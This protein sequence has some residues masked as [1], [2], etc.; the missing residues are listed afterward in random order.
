LGETGRFAQARLRWAK[1]LD[2]PTR[3]NLPLF[4]GVDHTVQLFTQ[5]RQV[6]DLAV[7]PRGNTGRSTV[8]AFTVMP[9]PPDLRDVLPS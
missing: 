7:I 4:A 3:C 8:N 6:G 5:C 2:D 9:I 1:C